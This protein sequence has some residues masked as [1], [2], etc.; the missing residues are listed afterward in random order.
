[1]SSDDPRRE[2]RHGDLE[3]RREEKGRRP[4]ERIVRIIR[5][6]QEE[7]RRAGPGVYVATDRVLEPETPLGRAI[8]AVRRVL[9]G[10]RLPSEAEA[11]ERVSKKVGL[12]IFASDNISSSAYATEEIVRVL[13]LAGI[14]TGALLLTMPLTVAVVAVLIVVVL[15][16][17]QA[18]RA[19][20]NGGGS[21]IVASQNLGMFPGLV[22][23][24]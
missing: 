21:Y 3:E 15:S 22:A 12:A 6:H 20:P 1:M 5:P 10:R 19:Y 8:D 2:G 9:I 23:A 13:A 11:T 16:Y 4:G 18:I 24:A 7:F 17:L 14:G